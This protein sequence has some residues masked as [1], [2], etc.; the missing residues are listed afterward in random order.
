VAAGAPRARF[1]TPGVE[2]GPWS[3]AHPAGQEGRGDRSSPHSQGR[4]RRPD[5]A[6]PVREAAAPEARTASQVGHNARSLHLRPWKPPR[7]ELGPPSVEAKP[8]PS[9]RHLSATLMA[10]RLKAR[11]IRLLGLHIAGSEFASPTD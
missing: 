4:L 7:P 10:P 5:L 3:G 2:A 9:C 1:A 6:P 11:L 8:Q